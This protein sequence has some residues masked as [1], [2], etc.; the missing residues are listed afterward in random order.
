MIVWC[1]TRERWVEKILTSA[2][3]G[4]WGNGRLYKDQV[5]LSQDCK[6][7]WTL[8]VS[9]TTFYC[10]RAKLW[11]LNAPRAKKMYLLQKE[12]CSLSV[13]SQSRLRVKGGGWR[14]GGAWFLLDTLADVGQ[15]EANKRWPSVAL[16]VKSKKPWLWHGVGVDYTARRRWV[17]YRRASIDMS[18]MEFWVHRRDNL[19]PG[20]GT[21]LK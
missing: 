6:C 7:V 9:T 1:A 21:S 4:V 3:G 10:S 20:K 17:I 8:L 19:W 2:G 13:F 14:R 11:W 16:G 5:C 12:R 18:L 15:E